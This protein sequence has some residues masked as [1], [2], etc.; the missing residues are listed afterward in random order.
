MNLRCPILVALFLTLAPTGAWALNCSSNPFTLTNGQTA[1]ATQVMANFNNLQNC[2]NQNLAHNGANSDITSL[3]GLSTP[4]SVGQGGTGDTALTQNNLLVGA[5][6]SAVTF[7]AP[8]TDGNILKV[9]GGVFVSSLNTSG[10]LNS[11]TDATNG[12]LN[13]VNGTTAGVIKLQPSDLLTKSVPTTADSIVL[14]D[15]AASNAAK[16]AT[17]SALFANAQPIVVVQDRKAAGNAG[18]AIT[19][20]TF[21]DRNLQTILLN[22]VPSGVSVSTPNIT[23]PAGTYDVDAWLVI[24]PGV[25][26][27]DCKSRMF[28]TTSSAVLQDIAAKDIVSSN[29]GIQGSSVQQVNQQ[30]TDRFTIAVSTQIKFQTWCDASTLAGSNVNGTGNAEDEVYLSAKF[31]RQN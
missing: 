14:M 7:V 24:Y 5:G 19:I 10:T 22:T 28:N 9:T 25:S 1:D 21:T 20:N 27:A 3:S 23:L 15:A 29:N 17:V 6:G 30:I 13:I 2:A 18:A 31:T 11:I 12:G 4:L 16:T 26:S 8:L